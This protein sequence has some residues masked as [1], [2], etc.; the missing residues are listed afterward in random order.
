M[1]TAL[2]TPLDMTR[3]TNPVGDLLM[4][5]Y[6]K[7]SAAHRI[8]LASHFSYAKNARIHSLEIS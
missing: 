2:A 5:E 1:N 4:L 8:R 6:Q 3:Q 7:S